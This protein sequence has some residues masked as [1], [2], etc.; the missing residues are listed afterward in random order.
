MRVHIHVYLCTITP[1][2]QTWDACRGATLPKHKDA[3]HTETLQHE[4]AA[5]PAQAAAAD[6]D[7]A[8]AAAC[9]I[10]AS[11]TSS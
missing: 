6:A 3:Q 7:T 2:V 11:C 10:A 9:A 8:A 4:D 5:I 1:F